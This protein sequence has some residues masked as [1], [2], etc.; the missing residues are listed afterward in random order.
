M[1]H[2]TERFYNIETHNSTRGKEIE[3]HKRWTHLRL[4]GWKYHNL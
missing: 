4:W 1:I 3:K 2:V